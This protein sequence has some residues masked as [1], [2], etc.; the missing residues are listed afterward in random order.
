MVNLKVYREM[1]EDYVD[2]FHLNVDIRCPV[3]KLSHQQA[4]S[5]E[6]VKAYMLKK[7]I[8]VLADLSSYLTP[9]EMDGVLAIAAQLKKEGYGLVIIELLGRDFQTRIT[10]PSSSTGR[11]QAVP[12]LELGWSSCGA[13]G[14]P[15][16]RRFLS[17]P[18]K[19]PTPEPKDV[20]RVLVSTK[21]FMTFL[22]LPKERC[23]GA[24]SGRF[25]PL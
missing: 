15:G 22:S 18:P 14:G 4:I 12:F 6:L 3:E 23:S 20:A 21:G 16:L 5:L 25:E 11:P 9:A 10:S 17:V 19:R 7:K 24:V 1:L 2:Q 13:C 8:I